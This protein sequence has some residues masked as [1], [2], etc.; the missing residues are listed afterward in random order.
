MTHD[1]AID[2][3]AHAESV[4][5]HS[6]PDGSGLLFDQ[7]SQTAYPIT[8]SARLIIDAHPGEGPLDQA[9]V[10]AGEHVLGVEFDTGRPLEERARTAS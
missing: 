2:K 3:V 9:P 4:Y 7:T 10:T 6:L 5:H 8:D 1:F